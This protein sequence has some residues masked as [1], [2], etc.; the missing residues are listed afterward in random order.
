MDI[1]AMLSGLLSERDRID[2]AISA[3]EALEGTPTPRTAAKPTTAPQKTKRRLSAAGRRRIAEAAR[4]RWAAVKAASKPAAKKPLAEKQGRKPMSPAAK[5]R[6][7]EAAKKRWAAKK[8]AAAK[9]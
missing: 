2:Q 7:S 4:K 6:I 9:A 8:A 5:K 3:L 1:A